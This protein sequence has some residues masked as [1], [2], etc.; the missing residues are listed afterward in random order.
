MMS[1]ES[2]TVALCLRFSLL[3]N[4]A[5]F[6][7]GWTTAAEAQ[8][9]PV[10]EPTPSI[11]TAGESVIR[12]APDQAFVNAAIESRASNPRD[13]SQQ[14]ANIMSA[15]RQRVT[16][17]GIPTDAL[18]TASYDV[19]QEVDFVQGRRV[20]RGYV[21]RNALEIRVDQV[22]RTG[23]IIDLAVQAGATSISGVRFELKDRVGAEREALRLAVA[24]AR[25]RAD[26]AAAG[27]GKT[28]DRILRIEETRDRAIQPMVMVGALART[29]EQATTPIEPGTIEIRSHVVM[30]AS[31][32]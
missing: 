7:F 6:A 3:V 9:P 22:E 13:A 20:P 8:Q 26:A 12:R 15:I 23:E 19:Q 16:A 28:I 5:L 29:A 17:A 4:L 25:G 27:A 2:T 11:V 18:R 24:D 21:A 32:K 10:P 30:T 1:G 31:F 14:A